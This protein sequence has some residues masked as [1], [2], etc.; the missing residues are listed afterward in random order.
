MNDKHK[1]ASR[2]GAF[3]IETNRECKYRERGEIRVLTPS[4]MKEYYKRPEAMEEFFYTD[5][6]GREWGCTGDVGYIDEDGFLFVEGRA[7][8]LFVEGI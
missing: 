8:D 6:D 4:R 3:D 1:I 7:T 5:K 2:I